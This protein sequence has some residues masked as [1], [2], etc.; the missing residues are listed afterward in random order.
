MGVLRRFVTS[1]AT[2][3]SQTAAVSSSDADHDEAE[4]RTSWWSRWRKQVGENKI[5][6]SSDPVVHGLIRTVAHDVW[7]LPT[8]RLVCKYAGVG[9]GRHRITV[10]GRF[11]SLPSKLAS[12][13]SAVPARF[14]LPRGR[15]RGRGP[16]RPS[17]AGS[18]CRQTRAISV[19]T[20]SVSALAIDCSAPARL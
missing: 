20:H 3:R 2:H 19:G 10:S 9:S 18:R 17:A 6:N 15:D 12:V 13:R 7:A 1:K 16:A 4:R 14:G 5:A 8:S 11:P